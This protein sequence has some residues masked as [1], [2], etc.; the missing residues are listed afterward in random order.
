[1]LLRRDTARSQENATKGEAPTHALGNP[2][3]IHVNQRAVPLLW[4]FENP[5]RAAQIAGLDI[6]LP[7]GSG[8]HLASG[9]NARQQVH[10]ADHAAVTCSRSCRDAV[11]KQAARA[12]ARAIRTG[13]RGTAVRITPC[14]AGRA[15]PQFAGAA[16]MSGGRASCDTCERSSG[17]G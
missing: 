16:Y 1:M 11:K 17:A 12:H 5:R 15:V 4:E 9:E 14:D 10:A 3:C 13:D 2:Y 6:N 8:Q 7:Q